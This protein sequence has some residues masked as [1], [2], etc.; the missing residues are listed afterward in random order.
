MVDYHGASRGGKSL[1]RH[2]LDGG[3]LAVKRLSR[4]RLA[5]PKHVR[6]TP[7]QHYMLGG[8]L[9]RDELGGLGLKKLPV[10][11]LDMVH[12]VGADRK[13]CGYKELTLG[14]VRLAHGGMDNDAAPGATHRLGG[15]RLS[16][17]LLLVNNVHRHVWTN[18]R[19]LRRAC[20]SEGD[21]LLYVVL[22]DSK[23]VHIVSI[24][25]THL[26]GLWLD[27]NWDFI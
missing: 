24:L 16:R 13:A 6:R 23:V 3:A 26:D 19:A 22:L 17:V 7:I 18:H 12:R 4:I 11:S 21:P 5:G 15:D 27:I 20:G 14:R 10:Y 9:A 25:L 1:P 2:Q 8:H